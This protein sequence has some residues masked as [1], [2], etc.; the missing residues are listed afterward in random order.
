MIKQFQDNLYDYSD[1]EFE[2]PDLFTSSEVGNDYS[3]VFEY[4]DL[5]PSEE[6]QDDYD[7]FEY[8]DLFTSEGSDDDDD[9]EEYYQDLETDVD[10]EDFSSEACITESFSNDTEATVL[11]SVPYIMTSSDSSNSATIVLQR[12]S[13]LEDKVNLGKT[14]HSLSLPV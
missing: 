4:P 8:E 2:Y 7:V 11:E 9:D 13:D 6:V 14:S 1:D 12:I 3:N 5:F 10:N